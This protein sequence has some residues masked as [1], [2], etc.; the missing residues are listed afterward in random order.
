[1]S[2][3]D[4]MSGCFASLPSSLTSTIDQHIKVE[5]D[6]AKI[7]TTS[8]EWDTS[9]RFVSANAL[10]AAVRKAILFTLLQKSEEARNGIRE[11]GVKRICFIA[12]HVSTP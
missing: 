8:R 1:M 6:E 11:G 5:Q 3:E 12:D 4:S 7:D 2:L 9:S 10:Y